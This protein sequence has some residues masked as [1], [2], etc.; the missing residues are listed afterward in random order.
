[1]KRVGIGD[2]FPDSGELAELAELPARDSD[3][4][5][6]VLGNQIGFHLRLA[7]DASF[8]AFARDVGLRNLKPG[9]FAGM[10]VIHNNPGISQV[11]LSRAIARDKSSVTP[12]IQ[13]LQR[14]DLVTRVRSQADRRRV[15]LELTPAGETV[16]RRLLFHAAA[17]DCRLDS[18]VGESKPEL[19]RLLKKI[20]DALA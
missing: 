6:G 20:E 18:I 10:M 8:R 4:M 12:L 14:H 15:T 7:Q 5:L 17:H 16:L 2:D 19:L 1:M 13:D 11:E 3:G 9:R